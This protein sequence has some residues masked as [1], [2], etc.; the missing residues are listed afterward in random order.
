MYCKGLTK[1]ELIDAGIVGVVY[2]KELDEWQVHRYWYKNN[3]TRKVNSVISITMAVGKHKYRT[4]KV[5]PKV[6]FSVRD[7]VN[8]RKTY[9]IPLS[10]LIYVWFKEDIPNGYV[11]DHIDNNSYNCSPNNLQMLTI[12]ENLA[13]RFDDNPEAWTNQWGKEKGYNKK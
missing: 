5:Y 2:L 6:T 13:K 4:D 1:Q 8:G 12:E 7:K 11:I 10:R 3:S 9:S